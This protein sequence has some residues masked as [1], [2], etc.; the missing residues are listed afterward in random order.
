M[1][2]KKKK[3]PKRNHL[4]IGYSVLCTLHRTSGISHLILKTIYAVKE[5]VQNTTNKQKTTQ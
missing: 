3:I 4:C 5:L 1:N 2:G